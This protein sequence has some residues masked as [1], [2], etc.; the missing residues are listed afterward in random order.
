MSPFDYG[1][2]MYTIREM[3]E[4]VSWLK[5]IRDSPTRIRLLRRL[6]KAQRGLLA[7]VSSVGNGVYEM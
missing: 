1:R 6:E 2:S 5:G 3:P 4:F 7:D